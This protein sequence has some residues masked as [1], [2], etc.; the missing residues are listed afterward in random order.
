MAPGAMKATVAQDHHR[1]LARGYVGFRPDGRVSSLDM[2]DHLFA[3]DRAGILLPEIGQLAALRHLSL[4]G[5]GLDGP[6][7]PEL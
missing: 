3:E 1:A 5:S 7:P 6:I 2:T 4:A